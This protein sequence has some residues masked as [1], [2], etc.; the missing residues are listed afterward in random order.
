MDKKYKYGKL[1]ILQE[2]IDKGSPCCPVNCVISHALRRQDKLISVQTSTGAAKGD[3]C[4]NIWNCTEVGV[5]NHRKL[6]YG[7]DG[8]QFMQDFD[9][10][11]KVYPCTLEYKEL[12]K[13]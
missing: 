5:Y 6:I 8:K 4:S 3:P 11:K 12:I 13:E 10:G 2:D 9:K 7:K 1:E